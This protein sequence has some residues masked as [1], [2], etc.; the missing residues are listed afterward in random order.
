MNESTTFL[1]DMFR[2]QVIQVTCAVLLVGLVTRLFARNRPFLALALWTVVLIKCLTPPVVYSSYGVFCWIQAYHT[3]APSDERTL[4][5]QIVSA[6]CAQAPE[7]AA[8]AAEVI[9]DTVVAAG[10][11]DD[12]TSASITPWHWATLVIWI[13]GALAWFLV[14]VLRTVRLSRHFRTETVTTTASI[15][16]LVRRLSRH[17][18]LR[19]PPRVVTSTN[20]IGPAVF[21]VLRPTLVLPSTLVREC[22]PRQLTPIV[23]HELM[24]VR[25]GDL[26]MALHSML[27]RAI[28]WFHPLVWWAVKRAAWES[29]RCCD[30]SVVALMPRDPARYAYSLIDVLAQSRRLRGI[31]FA[32]GVR[33]V[34]ITAARL[35]RVMSLGHGSHKR[36][37]LTCWLVALLAAALILPGTAGSFA[38]I[39]DGA[40]TVLPPAYAG[41]A[42]APPGHRPSREPA[43]DAADPETNAPTARTAKAYDLADLLKKFQEEDEWPT[44]APEAQLKAAL[45]ALLH[46]PSPEIRASAPVPDSAPRLAGRATEGEFRW[47]ERELIVSASEAVHASLEKEIEFWRQHGFRQVTVEVRIMQAS[48]SLCMASDGDPEEVGGRLS[49]RDRWMLF[50]Q[51]FANLESG[52]TDAELTAGRAEDG[53]PHPTG[54][55]AV[56]PDHEDTVSGPEAAATS[57]TSD[58]IVYQFVSDQQ[59]HAFIAELESDARA[60][61]LQAPKVTLFNGQ[62]AMISDTSQRPFVTD[63]QQV[64][65]D[66]GTTYQPVIKV[67]WEGAKIQLSPLITRDGHRVKCRFLFAAIK[68]CKTFRSPRYP[69]AQDIRVQHPIVATSCFECAIDVPAGQTLL[70]GGLFPA[71]REREAEQSMIGRLLGQSPNRIVRN[72]MTYIAITPRTVKTR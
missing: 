13:I 6:S 26:W 28:W 71:Q 66:A 46:V 21:G 25:R 5:A 43:G 72:E 12:R 39:P 45:A 7:A 40:P 19:R 47:N 1:C 65:D 18:G 15:A 27:V 59:V 20:D 29:E 30:E 31:S 37:P 60:N 17:V 50:P 51:E 32:P 22:R 55:A 48:P 69:D 62:T 2:V 23:L 9:D 38:Q 8:T 44:D 52:V 57:V 11:T 70:I 4:H 34:S 35:E 56:A 14:D 3:T 64:V 10:V 24:H 42:D 54:A 36:M 41:I 49:W 33:P 68:D 16:R 53:I 63:V 58:P 61:V 67:L